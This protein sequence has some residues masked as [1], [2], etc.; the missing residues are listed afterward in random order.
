MAYPSLLGEIFQD[1]HD[2]ELSRCF[3]NTYKFFR[4]RF[5][6]LHKLPKSEI[7]KICDIFHE[8]HRGEGFEESVERTD[9]FIKENIPMWNNLSLNPAEVDQN[10]Q[11]ISKSQ[12]Q[13]ENDEVL[14]D[15]FYNHLKDREIEGYKNYLYCDSEGYPT[16]GAGL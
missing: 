9:K 2:E 14:I 13:V 3:G 4:D 11:L 8:R 15:D 5:P 10:Q 7:K 16:T 12:N 6:G 1:E